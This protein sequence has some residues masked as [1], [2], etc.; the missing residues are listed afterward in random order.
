MLERGVSN[1]EKK[2]NREMIKELKT[3]YPKFK[4]FWNSILEQARENKGLIYYGD[5]P[6]PLYIARFFASPLQSMKIE[7]AVYNSA[8][9]E[10]P[11]AE[12]PVKKHNDFMSLLQQTL[13]KAHDVYYE[14]TE[15]LDKDGRINF[16]L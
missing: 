15:I 4:I 5:N 1:F 10:N 12:M 16:K 13:G 9:R 3:E 11:Q 6:S 14:E 2:T 8:F 7:M